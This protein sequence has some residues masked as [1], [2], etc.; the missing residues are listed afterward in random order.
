M[1]HH[2]QMSFVIKQEKIQEKKYTRPV[3]NN[4]TSLSENAVKWFQGR[5]ISQQ[6]LIDFKITE[7]SE[8]MPQTQKQVNTIQFNYFRSGELINTKFRDGA[9]NFKMV[10]DAELIFYNLDAI[11]TEKTCIITEGEIDCLSW[12][13]AG[14][15]NV[16]S[17]P[18]GASAGVKLDYLDNCIEYF[19]GMDKIYLSTDNDAPGVF[20]RDELARR[21]G[22][23]RCYKIDFG[24][25]KD[26]NEYLMYNGQEK[27]KSLIDTA[28]EFPIE[29]VFTINETWD[30]IQDIY[31]NGLPPGFK[32]GD[33]G[34]DEHIGFF[35]GEL[36]IITGIPGHGKSIY[37]DQLSLGL[38]I[39]NGW[40]FAICSPESYPL[41]FYFTRLIK[42]LIG[43]KFSQNNITQG[44]LEQARK[45]LQDRYYLI[46]PESGFSLDEI[47]TRA[48]QLVM[49]KGI[50]GLI[51][52]PWSRIESNRPLKIDEGKWIQQCLIRIIEFAQRSGVHVFLV[53]HP[54]KMQKDKDGINFN[55]PNLYSISGTAHFFNL[56]HNGI[57]VFRNYVSQRTEV[58]IQKVKWEHLGKVGMIEYRYNEDNSR[59]ENP[60]QVDYDNWLETKIYKRAMQTNIDL[61]IY[62]LINEND[63][64]PF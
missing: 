18:N 63:E 35:P 58:H 34:I 48:K 17:V 28:T 10:K 25:L 43:R 32:T 55:V 7:G 30:Q 64:P 1:C 54:T 42:R 5:G 19:V 9:K 62:N 46:M 4:N 61:E 14:I 13:E 6:T 38:S 22:I 11:V 23:E 39:L 52:D 15:K 49:R 47:L 24:S 44:Q 31:F 2:C 12:Y 16:V 50:N 33:K 57:T 51:L 40:K 36:T 3:F 59:F 37:L 56:T 8:W 21:L 26:A 29:G 45:W 20:L 60:A 53:A 27:L 41:A